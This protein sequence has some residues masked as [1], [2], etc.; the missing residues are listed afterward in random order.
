MRKIF[1]MLPVAFALDVLAQENPFLTPIGA[2]E[3]ITG[4]TG[5]ARDGSVG[6][7]L[8]NPAGMASIKST[9]LSAS[10][11]AFAQT[12]ISVKGDGVNED[13]KFFQTTPGQITTVFHQD[14]FNW[15]FSILV[16][17]SDEKKA[18]IG[19]SPVDQWDQNYPASTSI[20]LYSK[21][22]ELL[23]GPSVAFNLASNFKI[24]L[25]VFV[26]KKDIRGVSNVYADLSHFSA[27]SYY[28]SESSALALFPIL[29]V[30]YQ[31]SNDLSL[32]LK[33]SG[34]STKLSGKMES[35]YRLTSIFDPTSNTD[36]DPNDLWQTCVVYQ[37]T[38]KKS[39]VNHEKPI[40]IG[41]GLNFLASNNLRLLLD[42]SHQFKKEYEVYKENAEGNSSDLKLEAKTRY[43]FGLEYLT[44]Q[45]DALT[46]GLNY[47]PDP[48][49][50]SDLDFWGAAIGY[51][52]M[53]KIADSS[54]G[55]FYNQAKEDSNGS[56]Q[57]YRIIGLFISTS[58]NFLN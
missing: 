34:P 21:T 22:Q 18:N 24:G 14:K 30:L 46:F 56:E 53:D 17:R 25:S 1:Y 41:L 49:K 32:G 40:D 16:P 35:H 15:A 48:V 57:K 39:S 26:S 44:S 54:L 23:I 5:I 11:S 3:G 31:P 55:L 27:Q 9:K 45:T 8:Y 28:E 33:I 37:S 7:V 42:I 36:C 52:S 29:G 13:F 2:Y 10:G 43:N 19:T 50:D 4:N 12:D 38:K 6:S 58:I 51:R 47:N 20:D